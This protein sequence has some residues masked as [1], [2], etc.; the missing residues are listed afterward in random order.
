V[1]FQ[2][3]EKKIKSQTQLISWVW[4]RL[5]QR[6]LIEFMMTITI[7]ACS[8]STILECLT[9]KEGTVKRCRQRISA[10]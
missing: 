5:S 3:T 10:N 9:K 2:L 8:S 7:H 6:G 4:H 1:I